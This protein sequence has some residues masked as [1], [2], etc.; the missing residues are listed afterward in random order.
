MLACET[1]DDPVTQDVLPTAAHLRHYKHSRKNPWHT[2]QGSFIWSSTTSCHIH[3]H[4]Y[5]RLFCTCVRWMQVKWQVW[6]DKASDALK[7]NST[8]LEI[9]SPWNYVTDFKNLKPQTSRRERWKKRSCVFKELGIKEKTLNACKF[10]EC[11][12]TW[13]CVYQGYFTLFKWRLCNVSVHR[14]Q[15]KYRHKNDWEKHN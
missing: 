2:S 13:T 8:T 7:D 12:N 14:N 6:D 1:I 5:T 10:T 3:R 9:L 15:I 4:S 11:M